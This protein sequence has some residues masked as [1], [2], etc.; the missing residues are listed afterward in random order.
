M[1]SGP[2]SHDAAHFKCLLVFH[3]SVRIQLIFFI[4]VDRIPT[5]LGFSYFE[6]SLLKKR[7]KWEK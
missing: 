6:M 1:S 3:D 4:S 2:F 7:L 5:N